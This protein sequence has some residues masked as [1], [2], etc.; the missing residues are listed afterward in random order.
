MFYCSNV[1]LLELPG[2][3]PFIDILQELLCGRLLL[4]RELELRA[5]PRHG[6]LS[7]PQP[8]RGL[9]GCEGDEDLLYRH[10]TE[11]SVTGLGS[12]CRTTGR[13]HLVFLPLINTQPGLSVGPGQ[14]DCLT[15]SP[16]SSLPASPP[17]YSSDLN[18]HPREIIVIICLKHQPSQT[19]NKSPFI[20]WQS[21]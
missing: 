2:W 6:V 3:S 4:T 9:S 5:A 14:T 17:H 11:V 13:R 20:Q 19:T 7:H 8:V 21:V 18:R 1:Y 16:L 10:R 12:V 15:I